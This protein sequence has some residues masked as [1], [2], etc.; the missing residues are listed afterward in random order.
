MDKEVMTNDLIN[1]IMARAKAEAEAA[2]PEP[3]CDENT[4]AVVRYLCLRPLQVRRYAWWCCFAALEAICGYPTYGYWGVGKP[5]DM[6]FPED[7]D[8]FQWGHTLAVKK[9]R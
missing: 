8:Y 5:V 7:Y 1:I 2:K 4:V 3:K 9:T 6:S